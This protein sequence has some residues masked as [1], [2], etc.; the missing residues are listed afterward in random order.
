MRYPHSA[1]PALALLASSLLVS[2]C[3][4]SG[5]NPE[6]VGSEMA[7]EPT[8]R[9]VIIGGALRP[10]NAAVY[11]AVFEA[12]DGDGP[13]CVVP[14]AGGDPA[15]SMDSMVE[16]LTG[17]GGEGSAVGILIPSETPQ[18]AYD[19]AI[20]AQFAGCS[21]F[22]FTGGA[23]SRIL[24]TFMPQGDT[25]PAYRALWDR[26]QS[27]AVL[28]GSSA[29]AAMMSRVMI[30]SGNPTAAVTHGLA[31]EEDGDGIHITGGMGFFTASILDQHFLARGRIGRS[32]V[33][34]LAMDS[35][36]VSLGIDE[37]T[38]MVVD[39]DSAVVVGASGVVV[40]DA[41]SAQRE[42]EIR[43]TGIRV[44][45]AGDGDV[46]DLSTFEVRRDPTKLAVPVTDEAPASVEDPLA[47]WAFLR[48]MTGLASSPATHATF[49]A[50]GTTLSITEGDGFGAW[51]Q[52]LEGGV[53]GA[54]L[55]FGAGPFLVDLTDSGM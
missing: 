23:Q 6:S 1:L 20:V 22:Y 36:G 51:M 27:G 15:S 53:E 31:M 28:A 2:G 37:N 11:Q 25:T 44:T 9:L 35:V 54:P 8:G 21:G 46:I 41:R 7:E 49:T 48:V 45:L 16:R 52:A 5:T 29:G 42:S 43:G 13:V 34:A 40:V 30:A 17:Y 33:A 14:T 18:V 26:W 24:N 19:S 39:G 3:T 4:P 10:D 12:R 47:R 38:A 32:L 50:G 55:G